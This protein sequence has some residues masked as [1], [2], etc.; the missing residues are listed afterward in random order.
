MVVV[1]IS[2]QNYIKTNSVDEHGHD[3]TH[4]LSTRSSVSSLSLTKLNHD[5]NLCCNLST[6]F[7]DTSSTLS[8]TLT[9]SHLQAPSFYSLSSSSEHEHEH[10]HEHVGMLPELPA[11]EL[12]PLVMKQTSI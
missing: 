4:H 7:A 8:S 6:L 9:Q 3:S 2:M 1:F 10:E 12:R 5:V 11:Q